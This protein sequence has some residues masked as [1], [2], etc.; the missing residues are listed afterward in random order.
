M[1]N[2]LFCVLMSYQG[3]VFHVDI[4]AQTSMF[5]LR[6]DEPNTIFF[7]CSSLLGTFKKNVFWALPFIRTTVFYS[8]FYSV[9]YY[10]TV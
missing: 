3:D 6:G 9:Q 1:L 8:Y 10:S 4:S 2:Y 7:R 5:S